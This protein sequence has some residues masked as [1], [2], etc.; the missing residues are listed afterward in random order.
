[1]A[2]LYQLKRTPFH[3][4]TSG[5][6]LPQNWRR[7]AGHI[8]VGSYDLGLEREYWAIRNHAALIDVSPLFKYLI[9]GPDAA[10][11]LDRVMPRNIAKLNIGQV[12][13]SGWC[14]DDGKLLDDG[15]VTRLGEQ[16]FR[17]TVRRALAALARDDCGR[18]G[19]HRSPSAPTV[20][21][22]ALQG[23]NSRDVLNRCCGSPVDGLKFFGMAPNTLAGRAGDHLAHRLHR[24]PRLRD[25][26]GSPDARPSGTRCWPRAA[27]TAPSPAA[28]TP[29]T[30]RASRPASSCSTSTTPRAA[31]VD[32]GPEVLALELG[33]GWTIALDKPGNFVGRRALEREAREARP[34]SWSGSRWTGRALERSTPL[35]PAAADPGHGRAR[36]PSGHAEDGRQVG[37]A[38]TSTWSPV[39]KKYIALVHLERPHYEPGTRVEIELTVEYHRRHVRAPW[40]RRRS[41]IPSGSASDRAGRRTTRSSSA[42]VTTA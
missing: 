14:D 11:L 27:T 10:R 12:A 21:A 22:L 6:C 2:D 42:R 25:L 16:H 24:R 3:A 8:A 28:S 23:P 4:R 1:M 17:L 38:S 41:T 9:T 39:L 33:F 31:R 30:W 18:H 20:A 13:Y 34:G 15:T 7:W 36:Q 37:Y 29:W 5:L 35:R 19:R 32:R 40:S 26:D